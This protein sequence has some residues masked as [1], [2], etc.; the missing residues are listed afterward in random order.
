ML[1]VIKAQHSLSTFNAGS[2]KSFSVSC[3]D[4]ICLIKLRIDRWGQNK[5]FPHFLGYQGDK[6][7][8]P[9]SCKSMIGC[10][11]K[12]ATA[13][14]PAAFWKVQR[15]STRSTRGSRT[16]QTECSEK[17]MLGAFSLGGRMLLLCLHCEEVKKGP[18]QPPKYKKESHIY[19]PL[20]DWYMS[21]NISPLSSRLRRTRTVCSSFCSSWDSFPW[22]P[23][24]SWTCQRRLSTSPSL[25]SSA[26]SSLV[27]T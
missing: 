27:C 24:G 21:F 2:T 18:W 13:R 8:S 26:P 23:T 3:Y 19:C 1:R 4:I 6:V 17:K 5:R 14:T 15:F 11:K 20:V 10:L 22:L 12:R 7:T 25:S 9:I 16:K